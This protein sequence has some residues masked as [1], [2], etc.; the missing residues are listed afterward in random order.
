MRLIGR[1]L[2]IYLCAL[3]AARLPTAGKAFIDPAREAAGAPADDRRQHSH[4]AVVGVLVDIESGDAARLAGP[5]IALP[6]ADPHKAQIV[7]LDVAVMALADMPEQ[8]RLAEPVIRRLPEGARAG[9]RAAAI[10][11]PVADDVP[12]RDV[13]HR[14]LRPCSECQRLHQR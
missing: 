6:A 5:Q 14:D 1:D 4:L 12:I 9:D 8:H 11:E 7:E 10:V 2:K 3:D 13:A